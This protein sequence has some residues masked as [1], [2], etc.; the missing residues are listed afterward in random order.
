MSAIF[1][2]LRVTRDKHGTK[3]LQLGA[4]SVSTRAPVV[5]LR[6]P[7][8]G[9]GAPSVSTQAPVVALQAPSVGIGAPNATTGVHHN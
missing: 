7:S 4:R 8:V 5:A 2:V 9:I 6:A 3:V 1:R